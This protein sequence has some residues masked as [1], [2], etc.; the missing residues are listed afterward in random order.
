VHGREQHAGAL[1]V[2]L[3]GVQRLLDRDAR[4]LESGHVDD[5]IRPVL[6]QGVEQ[7]A[8]VEDAAMHERHVGCHEAS[9]AA[10]EIVDH[11]GRE[12]RLLQGTNHVRTDVA[13][14][15]G[16]EPGHAFRLAGGAGASARDLARSG[17]AGRDAVVAVANGDHDRSD[18]RRDAQCCEKDHG[19]KSMDWCFPPRVA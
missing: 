15:T 14:T 4:V 9:V 6:P 3:V 19:S 7:E 18:H 1:D 16:H 17:V 13:G 12:A 11:D 5:A 8:A 2:L 10:R